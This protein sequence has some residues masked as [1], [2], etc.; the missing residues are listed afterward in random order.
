MTA[1][2]IPNGAWI[3][4]GDGRKAVV[5]QNHGDETM[6][7]FR[8][9]EFH[10]RRSPGTRDQGSDRPGRAYSSGGRRSAVEQTDWH[11]VDEVRFVSEIADLLYQAAHTGAFD[12]LVLVAPPK[13]LGQLRDELHQEV[14][15]RV[16]GEVGKD[17]VNMEVAEVE[18]LL[19]GRG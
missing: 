10:E 15:K 11:H 18:R 17:L 1:R 14:T 12:K 3:F 2:S 5:F 6:P 13:V 19:T 9:V 7:D 8:V 16:V 4:V